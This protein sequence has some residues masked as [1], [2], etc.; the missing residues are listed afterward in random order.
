[1]KVD[2]DWQQMEELFYADLGDGKNSDGSK[3]S[4]RQKRARLSTSSHATGELRIAFPFSSARART[5]SR[6]R[7]RR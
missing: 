2:G 1:M 3:S 4:P 6:L 5:S 7:A